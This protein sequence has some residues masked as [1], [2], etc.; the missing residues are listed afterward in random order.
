MRLLYEFDYK[1]YRMDGTIGRRPSVRAVIV[2]GDKIAMVYS[3]KHDYY[4]FP[5]GGIDEGESHTDAL[6]REVR[7]ELG[8]EVIPETIKEYGLVLRKEKGFFED[9]FIQ[10]NF[11]YLCKAGETVVPQKLEDYEQEEEFTLRWVSS[12]EAIE[13]NRYHEH[14]TISNKIY[15]QR[16]VERESQI[17]EKLIEEGC[18]AD[19]P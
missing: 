11:F 13:T 8:L 18:V 3:E 17:I 9:L 19:A 2:N 14:G 7:E 5:G 10:E 15:A 1:D 16:M 4:T 6:I 12:G